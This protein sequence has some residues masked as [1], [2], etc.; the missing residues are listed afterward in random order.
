MQKMLTVEDLFSHWQI[1]RFLVIKCLMF[2]SLRKP[3]KALAQVMC[4]NWNEITRTATDKKPGRYFTLSLSL[5]RP[6]FS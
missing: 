1:K 6:T 5:S 4:R 3:W 2:M